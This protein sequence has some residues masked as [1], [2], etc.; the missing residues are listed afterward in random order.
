V[1][2]ILKKIAEGAELQVTKVIEDCF[3]VGFKDMVTQF[4][5]LALKNILEQ[6][7]K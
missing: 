4:T 1:N 3:A 6:Y 7:E 2:N 5:K